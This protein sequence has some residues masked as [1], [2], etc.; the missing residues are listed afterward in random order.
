MWFLSWEKQKMAT[1][2]IRTTYDP[3][4]VTKFLWP[5]C[6]WYQYGI[7]I[8]IMFLMAADLWVGG[9]PVLPC[10]CLGRQAG[11]AWCKLW[12]KQVCDNAWSWPSVTQCCLLP[13]CCWQAWS[14]ECSKAKVKHAHIPLCTYSCSVCSMDFFNWA[15]VFSNSS[16]NTARLSGSWRRP[17][18]SPYKHV[19]VILMC[20]CVTIGRETNLLCWRSPWQPSFYK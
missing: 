19:V 2:T 16:Q 5:L 10:S 13:Q 15:M 20:L 17:A 12:T 18:T 11:H 8:S 4:W 1:S 14:S 7:L 3:G 6:P 9:F